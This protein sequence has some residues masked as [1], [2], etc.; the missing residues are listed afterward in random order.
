MANFKLY[1]SS[2]FAGCRLLAHAYDHCRMREVRIFMMPGEVESVGV[3]D[4]VDTWIA[5]VAA[6][7]FSVNIPRIIT[8]ILAG[9]DIR[10]ANAP[11]APQTRRRAQL[12]ADPATAIKVERRSLLAPIAQAQTTNNRNRRALLA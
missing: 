5:P 12:V 9:K 7:P 2:K 10:V 4:G 1:M 3:S 8:D 11:G 6:D